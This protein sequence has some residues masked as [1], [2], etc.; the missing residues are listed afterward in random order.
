MKFSTCSIMYKDAGLD[1]ACEQA[2]ATGL[3]GIDLWMSPVMCQHLPAQPSPQEFSHV[4]RLLDRTGLAVASLT[5]YYTH[6]PEKGLGELLNVL[7]VA[8]ELD[9]Q[10]VIT[11]MVGG[12]YDI[13]LDQYVAYFSPAVREAERLGVNIAFE[14]H[15]SAPLTKTT[16]LILEFLDAFPSPNLGFT[17]APAHLVTAG[18]DVEATIRAVG[19]RVFFLYAWDHIPGVDDDGKGTFIWPPVDPMHHFPGNGN[20]P[21]GDYL[22]ALKAV[23]YDSRGGWLNIMSH[24]CEA[25]PP[26]EVSAAVGR[27]MAWLKSLDA[28]SAK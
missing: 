13:S 28:N 1:R 23:G 25:W 12:T 8:K 4:R 3:D 17:I 24:G 5:A 11:S 14:N 10:V 26:E 2:A 16:E 22:A 18:C 15:S 7:N 19:E 6:S 9:A 21:F 27:S 20:L